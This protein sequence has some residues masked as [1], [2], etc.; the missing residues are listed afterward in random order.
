MF[1]LEQIF[2]S[3]LEEWL[4]EADRNAKVGTAKTLY[5]SERYSNNFSIAIKERTAGTPG[6][7]LR[8]VDNFGRKNVSDMAL[9]DQRAD[10]L[11]AQ[12]FVDDLYPFSARTR[13][14]L[15]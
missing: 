3:C 6:S 2:L 14:D 8:I 1:E 13:A 15:T 4:G 5:D 11:P 12:E 9:S 7:G 10:E